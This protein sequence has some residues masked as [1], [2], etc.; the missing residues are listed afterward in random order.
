MS[1]ESSQSSKVIRRATIKNSDKQP[2]N[3]QMSK[4]FSSNEFIYSQ[5]SHE[6]ISANTPVKECAKNYGLISPISKKVNQNEL[7]QDPKIKLIQ[8]TSP[9]EINN[10]ISSDI[11]K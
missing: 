5:V 9:T 2:N 3:E 7:D 4:S 6:R 8:T 11:S 10:L 1:N